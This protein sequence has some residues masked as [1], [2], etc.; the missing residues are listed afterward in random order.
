M[1]AQA[2][3]AHLPEVRKRLTR[4]LEV[5][6]K[7]AICTQKRERLKAMAKALLFLVQLEDIANQNT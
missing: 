1:H 5:I 6:S 4:H 7:S 3:C 2:S